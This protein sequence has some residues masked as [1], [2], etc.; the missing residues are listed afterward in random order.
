LKNNGSSK[1]YQL[2]HKT[3]MNRQSDAGVTVDISPTAA[4]KPR[5]ELPIAQVSIQTIRAA[6]SITAWKQQP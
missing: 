5:T 2:K 3:E 1:F 4:A 6:K